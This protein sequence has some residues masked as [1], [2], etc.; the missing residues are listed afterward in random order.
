VIHTLV[1]TNLL[2]RSSQDYPGPLFPR[3]FKCVKVERQ[4]SVQLLVDRYAR[5]RT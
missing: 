5:I 4:P 3:K 1:I 2:P